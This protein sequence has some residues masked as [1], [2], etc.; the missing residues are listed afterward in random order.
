[1][2]SIDELVIFRSLRKFKEKPIIIKYKWSIWWLLSHCI[3]I[4]CFV[5]CAVGVENIKMYTIARQS[6]KSIGL[7]QI[8]YMFRQQFRI[9][10][11]I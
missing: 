7:Y 9:K 1:M 11:L 10:D 4:V 5:R 3:T 2:L 6:F 8:L